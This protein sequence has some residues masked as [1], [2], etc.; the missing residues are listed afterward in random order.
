MKNKEV[1]PG[2]SLLDISLQ[3]CGALDTVFTI[4]EKN[5]MSVT[6][7]LKAGF[8]IKADSN[9]YD[10]VVAEYRSASIFPATALSEGLLPEGIGFMGIEIDFIVS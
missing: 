6:D 4:A 8:V 10:Q 2:Q 7:D 3:E 5:G 9:E 1:L